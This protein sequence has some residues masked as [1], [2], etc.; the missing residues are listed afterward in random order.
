VTKEELKT[1][2]KIVELEGSCLFQSL[3]ESCPFRLECLPAFIVDDKE[4]PS[5]GLRAR[6]ALSA[7][8]S[9][10]LEELL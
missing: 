8:S 7:L 4:P 5:K 1:L 3:C 2:E 6:W 9:E 10:V